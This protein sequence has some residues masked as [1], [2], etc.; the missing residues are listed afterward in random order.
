MKRQ[1]KTEP[2]E[3]KLSNSHTPA[4]HPV[5]YSVIDHPSFRY[6]S[7]FSTAEGQAQTTIQH[8]HFA[9]PIL[10]VATQV[11]STQV[12]H[13]HSKLHPKAFTITTYIFNSPP[14][15]SL[16]APRV[17]AVTHATLSSQVA[18]KIAR[19]TASSGLLPS[20]PQEH[21]V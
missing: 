15:P 13:A 14:C 18:A 2:E 4:D 11:V 3:L 21:A 10:P 16:P 19:V 9:A 6:R 8:A 5:Y 17:L 20:L 12:I 7:L 1:I